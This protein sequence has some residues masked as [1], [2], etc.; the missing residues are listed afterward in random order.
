M[1]FQGSLRRVVMAVVLMLVV[2]FVV[3]HTNVVFPGDGFCADLENP[4][5]R[6]LYN[7][8]PLPAGGGGGGAQ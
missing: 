2:L 5:L 1:M 6:W 7:C 3:T 8:P 4:F